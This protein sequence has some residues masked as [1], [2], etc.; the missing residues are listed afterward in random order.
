M[1]AWMNRVI[2]VSCACLFLGLAALPAFAQS[3]GG[4]PA[5]RIL[6]V[7]MQRVQKESVAA[8]SVQSQVQSL[9]EKMQADFKAL[10]ETL[11]SE[12]E[13]LKQQQTLLSPDAFDE[14]RREFEDRVREEERQLQERQRSI[15]IA[16]RNAQRDILKS[17][18]PILR[19]LKDE[20][21]GNILM[22]RQ[23]ILT[24]D[25]D[26]DITDTVIQRLNAALPYVSVDLPQAA[27]R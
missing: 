5:A 26:L 8:Q 7:D 18:D 23:M 11:Q 2:I 12:Q 4:V 13:A 6:I 20:K 24:G 25:S 10:N 14:R 19:T 1:Q 17:L 15:Q 9:E 27:A 3:G 16:F 22:D 21:G